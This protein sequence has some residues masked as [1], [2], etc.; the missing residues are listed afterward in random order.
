MPKKEQIALIN[1]YAKS[2]DLDEVAR[3]SLLSKLTENISN[4]DK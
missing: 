2:H 3:I 1:E 4:V